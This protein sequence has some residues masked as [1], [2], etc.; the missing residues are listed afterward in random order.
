[1]AE[2]GVLGKYLLERFPKMCSTFDARFRCRK[3]ER[4]DSITSGIC[5]EPSA[6][7]RSHTVSVPSRKHCTVIVVPTAT[8]VP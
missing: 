5:A 1:M 3:H 7:I 6:E 4:R 2:Q 8:A